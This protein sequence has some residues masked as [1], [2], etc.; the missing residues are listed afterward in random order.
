MHA[1]INDLLDYSR[2]RH[3]VHKTVP[4]DLNRIVAKVL[5]NLQTLVAEQGAEVEWEGLPE[6]LG[7]P[8]HLTRLM[9]NLIGNALK[10]RHP[11]RS[12]KIWIS[13]EH[14]L[15]AWQIDIHDNG[16]G[17]DPQYFDKIFQIFQRLHQPEDYD[18]TGIGLAICKRIAEQHGGGIHVSSE[19]GK[20]STFHVT[21]RAVPNID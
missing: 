12:P 16:I 21:L 19:P 1:L 11:E 8:P 2:L 3:E 10:Y 20:G 4:C 14:R 18:G 7:D 13:A 15:D 17:I 9:Q 5:N 6:V